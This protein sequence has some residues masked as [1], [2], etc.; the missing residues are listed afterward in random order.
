[1]V[2]IVVD[3]SIF[4]EEIRKGSLE[5]AELAELASREE[6]DLYIPVIIITE[7]WAGRSMNKAKVRALVEKKLGPFKRIEVNEKIARASGELIRKEQVKGIDA[8]VAACCLEK[9]ARLA[10]LNTKHFEKVKGLKL[11]KRS[12]TDPERC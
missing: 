1:M 11:W 12:I 9:R 6:V 7:L 4:I 10:T 2:K 8:I 3:T 5:L